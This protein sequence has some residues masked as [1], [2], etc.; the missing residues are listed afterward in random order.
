MNSADIKL[1]QTEPT[2]SPL[3]NQ[4]TE[5]DQPPTADDDEQ[6]ML[7]NNNER[8]SEKIYGD[9]TEQLQTE[10]MPNCLTDHLSVLT[11]PSILVFLVN[12]LLW[13]LGASVSIMVYTFY[14]DKGYDETQASLGMTMFGVGS[15]A[16]SLSVALVSIILRPNKLCFHIFSNLLMG[17]SALCLPL[18]AF[19]IVAM[20]ISLA[21]MGFSYGFICANLSAV[22]EHINGSRLLYLVYSYEMAVA[23]VGSLIGPVAGAQIEK[24]FGLGT[25]FYFSAAAIFA[26]FALFICY[27]VIDRSILKRFSMSVEPTNASRI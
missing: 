20:T 27:A 24:Q 7:D 21:L 13:N 26:A 22:I 14:T 1:D 18:L 23:G 5:L 12:C 11:T 2:A 16:G 3:L 17:V 6:E 19:N 15:L 25:Q 9:T 4:S 8:D 10:E